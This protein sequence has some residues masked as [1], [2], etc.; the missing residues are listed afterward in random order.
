M[1][2][3]DPLQSTELQRREGG[4]GTELAIAEQEIEVRGEGLPHIRQQS[5][6]ALV[7]R[8]GDHGVHRAGGQGEEAQHL[9]QGKPTPGLLR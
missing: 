2:A 7:E 3:K 9:H 1:E 6:L 5:M 4:K 8:G